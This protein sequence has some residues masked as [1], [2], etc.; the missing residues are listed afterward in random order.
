MIAGLQGMG[1]PRMT[2][3]SLHCTFG[4]TFYPL[5]IAFQKNELNNFFAYFVFGY[6]PDEE[7]VLQPSGVSELGAIGLGKTPVNTCAN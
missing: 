7:R 1:H 3:Y 4:I 2:I 6:K 5:F